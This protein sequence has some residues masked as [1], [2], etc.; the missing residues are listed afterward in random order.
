MI[1]LDI[2]KKCGIAYYH[3]GTL[4]VDTV[5]GSPFLQASRALSLVD[6]G[7]EPIVG[8]E[9][10]HRFR[11]AN[12]TRSILKR[13]GGIELL[14]SLYDV[15]IK[16]LHHGTARKYIG[17]KSKEDCQRIMSEL[18]G[19]RMTTDE[20]DA[21][22][23]IMLHKKLPMNGSLKFK[24]IKPETYKCLSLS[25]VRQELERRLLLGI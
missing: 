15:E 6:R 14:L 12:T 19:F 3:N 10:L 18:A 11:N 20:A 22:V 13:V 4:R 8:I 2:A 24:R 9:K 17:A 7:V 25:K 21:A 23:M 16:Y 5:I 1:A